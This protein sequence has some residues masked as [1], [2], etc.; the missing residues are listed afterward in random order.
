MPRLW[1]Y[2]KYKGDAVYVGNKE[3]PRSLKKK[4]FRSKEDLFWATPFDIVPLRTKRKDG[5]RKITSCDSTNI[6]SSYLTYI[7]MDSVLLNRLYELKGKFLFHDFRHNSF[8]HHA[9]VLMKLANGLVMP[10]DMEDILR[11]AR[12]ELRNS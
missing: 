10:L 11:V 4:E 7:S 6:E 3:N 8:P 9:N 12:K 5:S 2:L 1:E